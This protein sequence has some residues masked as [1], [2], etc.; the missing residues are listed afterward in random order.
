MLVGGPQKGG[1]DG[2]V[3]SESDFKVN[4][5]AINWTAAFVYATAAFLQ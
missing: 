3:D 4:E 1:P 5:V 2:W